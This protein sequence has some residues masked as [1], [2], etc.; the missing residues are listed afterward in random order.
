MCAT[1]AAESWLPATLQA[2][3]EFL[4]TEGTD[5][6][7]GADA[8]CQLLDV[9]MQSGRVGTVAKMNLDLTVTCREP[10]GVKRR[11]HHFVPFV[12]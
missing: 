4:Y 11:E 1:H 7:D 5:F 8:T 9:A 10:G 3:L 6:P 2:F 12:S